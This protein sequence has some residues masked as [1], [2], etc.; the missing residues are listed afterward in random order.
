MD[1]KDAQDGTTWKEAKR[2]TKGEIHGWGERR[3]ADKHRRT[4]RMICWRESI[5]YL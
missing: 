4:R 5:T 1:R 2:K 3:H